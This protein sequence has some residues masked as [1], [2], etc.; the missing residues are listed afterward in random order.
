MIQTRRQTSLKYW[1]GMLHGMMIGIVIVL[2]LFA[3]A[4]YQTGMFSQPVPVP[5]H[6]PCDCILR[7][8]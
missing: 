5:L 7:I 4:A 3:I 8:A 2:A 6:V 1:L